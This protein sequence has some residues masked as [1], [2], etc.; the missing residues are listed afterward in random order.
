MTA[1]IPEF[2]VSGP[3]P[4]GTTVLEAS[5]GTG[6]TYTIAALAADLCRASPCPRRKQPM[7][8]SGYNCGSSPR[9]GRLVRSARR[10]ILHIDP[11]WPGPP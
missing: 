9:A 2:D 11:T 5:A 3:L 6:K 1:P 8:Q 10:H 7:S 4:K